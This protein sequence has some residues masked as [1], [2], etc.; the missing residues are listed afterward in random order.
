MISRLLLAM[1]EALTADCSDLFL[2]CPEKNADG[3]DTARPPRVYVG[4]FPAKRQTGQEAREFPC[5]VLSPVSGFSSEGQE[6]CDVAAFLC[7]YNNE[8][9]DAEG[10]E[11]ELAQLQNA[12]S[13]F[14]T[15][16]M[17]NPLDRRYQV[18]ADE[19]GRI[20]RWQRNS[21]LETPRPYLQMAVISRWAMPGWQ[22]G[23][24]TPHIQP[25]SP[26]K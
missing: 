8:Q 26:A 14:L 17:F 9:G 12:V 7:V 25:A 20:Y 18:V 6:F 16:A 13:R 11:M 3:K 21:D 23:G 15:R 5:V 24:Q 4:D 2:S 22:Y 1:K 19:K 10:L